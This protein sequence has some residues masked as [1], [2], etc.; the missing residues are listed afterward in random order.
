MGEQQNQMQR[1][2]KAVALGGIPRRRRVHKVLWEDDD[3]RLYLVTFTAPCS[4]WVTM[5]R[6]KSGEMVFTSQK[7]T[8]LASTA[9]SKNTVTIQLASP[10]EDVLIPVKNEADAQCLLACLDTLSNIS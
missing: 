10:L 5:V 2:V 8:I 6:S 7:H 3:Y 9:S 1:Q 4:R